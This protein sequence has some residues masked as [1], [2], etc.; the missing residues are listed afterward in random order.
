MHLG[1]ARA[2]K[3]CFHRTLPKRKGLVRLGT[4]QPKEEKDCLSMRFLTNSIAQRGNQQLQASCP[5]KGHVIPWPPPK[6]N[7]CLLLPPLA[8]RKKLIRGVQNLASRGV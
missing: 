2:P 8:T 6:P 3:P 7:S 1:I 4:D 5:R